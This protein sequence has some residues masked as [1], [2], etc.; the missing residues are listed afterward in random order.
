V[1]ALQPVS[2]ETVNPLVGGLPADAEAFGQVADGV[3][4]QL[5]VFE[6]PLS[7]FVH[8]NTFPGHGRHLPL[9]RKCYPCPENMCYRCPEKI[10]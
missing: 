1:K 9:L 6:K 10:L 4:V 8:G 7:L 5:V 2:L 3:V